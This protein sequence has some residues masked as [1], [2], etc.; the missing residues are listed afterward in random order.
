MKE[1][2]IPVKNQEL[3]VRIED[4]SKNGEGIGHTEG[5]TLFIK[6]AVPGDV[7]RCGITKACKNY[8]YARVIEVVEPSPD[9]CDP[10]CA[11]ARRCGGCQLMAVSYEAQLAFKQKQVEN[12]LQRIGGFSEL[13]V[14]SVI[15]AEHTARYRNKAQYPVGEVNGHPAAGFYARRSHDIIE[16][17]DCLLSP[18]SH[19]K[20]LQVILRDMERY[21]IS[22]YDEATGKGVVR[23]ILIREGFATGEIHV[24]FIINGKKMP[25][26]REIA[27]ELMELRF[28]EDK[29]SD[30]G[31]SCCPEKIVGV[32]LNENTG[33][34]NV[35]LGKTMHH[36]TGKE[37]A[38]DCIG[39][40]RY[41]I[42][43]LSFYQVNPEQ[44]KKLYD[45]V[46]AF[47]G[48]TGKEHVWDLYCGI[49]TIGLYLADG[50]KK[51]TGIEIVPSAVEDAR[52]NAAENGF[53]NAEYHVGA[54]EKIMPQLLRQRG[55]NAGIKDVV[56]LDPPRKG[57]DAALLETLLA[58]GTE[59][60]V[61]VSCDPATLARDL[62]ILADGGYA[63]RKVQPVD[64]FP[65]TVHIETVCLL[66]KLSEAKHHISVQVDMEEL[67]VTA[68]ESKATYEEIQEWVQEKYGFHVSHLNIAKTKRK[69]GIIER[70]N[71]N[72][73]KSEDSRSPETPKEKEEAI[74]AA[75]KAFQMI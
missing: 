58:L 9:R 43:P 17:D 23:H 1:K 40:V 48:L 70:Q 73:P 15:G 75:F 65:Q 7:V 46:K 67:D 19:R 69:C 24:C 16:N 60:I 27:E 2:S 71:Y 12:A 38:A 31:E 57:C 11:A 13:P 10:P 66:S 56:I 14:L 54:A 39:S 32:S 47:A 25:H 74:V 6:D 30:P 59:K 4:F 68:A 20:I 42:S 26:A 41:E 33:R 53:R 5:Y 22:A 44:T 61:Y 36:I 8:G 64:M 3:T 21:G 72:L 18:L 28:P 45:T 63:V 51:V 29:V 52:R 37:T 62:R 34:G 55:D 50:A 35:I 49:G